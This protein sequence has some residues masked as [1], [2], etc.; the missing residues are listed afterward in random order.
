M[1]LVSSKEILT[2]ARKKKYGV[3]SLLAGNLELVIGPI[4]AA[5]KRKSPLILPFNQE[6][7]PQVPIELGKSL[8]ETFRKYPMS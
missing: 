5:E 3:P 6:V 2:A 1:P 8:R 7:T 4:K